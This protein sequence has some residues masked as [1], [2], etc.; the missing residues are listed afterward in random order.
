MAQRLWITGEHAHQRLA[1]ARARTAVP[2]VAPIDAHRRRYGPYTAT[3]TLFTALVP[4]LLATSPELVRRHDIEVLSVAPDLRS[5]VPA[6]RETLT[7]LAVP[8]ERTRFYSRVRTLRLSH[9]LVELLRDHLRTLG[10]PR[11]TLVLDRLDEADPTDAEFVSV[12]LRRL[13]PDLLTVI[14]GTGT[15]PLD[16]ALT[17]ALDRYAQ[18]LE[19]PP[20]PF[21]D[22]PADPARAYVDADCCADEPALLAAYA[23]LDP[24]HRRRLHARRAEELLATGLRSPRLGAVPHHLE[25]AGDPADTGAKALLEALNY[26]VDMGFYHATLDL[27]RR[28]RA[29]VDRAT[30][31]GPWWAFTTKMTTSLSALGHPEEA[32]KLYDEARTLSVN[33]IIHRQAAYATAMIYTRHRDRADRDHLRARAWINQA[34]AIASLQPEGADRSFSTV[35]QQNGLALIELHLGNL[36]GALDLVSAGLDRLDEE[37]GADEHRLHRSVLLHNRAQVL[38]ALGRLDEALADFTAVIADDP[39][40]PEYHFDRANLLHRLGRD[41][42]ALAG[43][44]DAIRLGPPFPEAHY[45]RADVLAGLGQLEAALDD[46]SYVLELEPD[47]VDALVNRAGLY[48][49]LDDAAA[50]RADLD[51]GLAL[52]G[53]NPHLLCL[54]GQSQ[55]EQGR[56]AEAE[57]SYRRALAADPRAVAAWSGLAALAFDAGDPSAAVGHLDRALAVGDDAALRYNRATAYRALGRYDD[58]VADLARAAELDPTDEDVRRERSEC[59]RALS[60]AAGH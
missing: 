35:F 36:P 7:S 39:N 44:A 9:G 14:V 34:I 40:H 55:A 3:N 2:L 53:D 28:G 21:P 31:E 48:A 12:L 16:D 25:R 42:E 49:V 11:R 29:A 45:N 46:L 60:L 30:Q 51:A 41:D 1:A 8:A 27:G 32:E 19:A 38:A 17:V 33:P 22:P 59:D 50:L 43:Y 23:G 56:A 20:V 13:D 4:D 47:N 52:D 10:G 57:R 6:S 24:D 58:A 15:G 18:R 5:L 26:C 54:L 37:L